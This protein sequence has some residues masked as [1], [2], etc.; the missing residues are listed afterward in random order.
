MEQVFEI[1]MILGID[2][3]NGKK[4]QELVCIA[5]DK[6]VIRVLVPV[7]NECSYTPE[8]GSWQCNE[9]EY[10]NTCE[11]MEPCNIQLGE[12]LIIVDKGEVAE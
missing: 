8:E 9:C 12:K 2:C 7:T 1:S 3:K 10:K 11:I 5:E 4:Y 6:K